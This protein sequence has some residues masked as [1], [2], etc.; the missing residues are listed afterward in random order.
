MTVLQAYGIGRYYYFN[1]N[2][3]KNIIFYNDNGIILET[4][5]G[6]LE[7]KGDITAIECGEIANRN[8]I[9]LTRKENFVIKTTEKHWA[10]NKAELSLY[11]YVD[12][13]KIKVEKTKDRVMTYQNE[14]NLSYSYNYL[15][16]FEGVVHGQKFCVEI[17]TK[18]ETVEIAEKQQAKELFESLKD[19]V[20][21]D[22]SDFY[23]LYNLC[24][25]SKRNTALIK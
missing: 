17:S 6:W 4:K 14:Y 16:T 22:E 24:E 9:N 21:I 20:H 13:D 15:D 23:R 1:D 11:L 10:N 2:A 5:Q 8:K 18:Y 7:E 3:I 19:K 12:D 25:I